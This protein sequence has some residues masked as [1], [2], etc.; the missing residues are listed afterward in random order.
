VKLRLAVVALVCVLCAPA[1]AQDMPMSALAPA[2][3]YF[4]HYKLSVLGI[5]NTIR[6]VGHRLEDGRDASSMID[7]PLAFVTDA[8]RDW[9]RAYPR[10]PWIAKDLLALEVVYLRA[11]APEA[12]P[13][14]RRT[15]FWLVRD[16]PDAAATRIGRRRLALAL[17][18]DPED[19]ADAPGERFA[20]D[21][22]PPS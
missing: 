5:A 11:Q 21:R 18:E 2:D 16:Y 17:G 10:D 6:D 12:M 20:T 9:E 22:Q 1:A 13:L 8:I 7:G 14:A 3:E 15:E 19:D 4:G